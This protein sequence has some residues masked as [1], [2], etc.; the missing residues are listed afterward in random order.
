LANPPVHTVG[1][2]AKI[3]PFPF[4]TDA[5][6]LQNALL[7]AEEVGGASPERIYP[8]VKGNDNETHGGTLNV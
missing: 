5:K 4:R 7:Y 2:Y 1:L 3:H 8:N 6:T